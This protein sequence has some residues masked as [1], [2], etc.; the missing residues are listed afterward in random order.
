MADV[1][2]VRIGK[3]NL[4][5]LATKYHLETELRCIQGNRSISSR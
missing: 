3:M 1:L 5:W 2:G 4:L